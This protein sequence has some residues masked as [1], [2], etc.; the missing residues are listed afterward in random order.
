[1]P[2]TFDLKALEKRM[3]LRY[4][5]M[6]EMTRAMSD[7]VAFVE[8]HGGIATFGQVQLMPSS[9]PMPEIRTPAPLTGPIS[10]PTPGTLTPPHHQQ[11]HIPTPGMGLQPMPMPNLPVTPTDTAPAQGKNKIGLIIGVIVAVGVTVLVMR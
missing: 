9:A 11:P 6:E 8:Q 5:T 7:P 10:T 4:P 3:E 2:E 1:M